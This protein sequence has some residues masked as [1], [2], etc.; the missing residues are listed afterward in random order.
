[1]NCKKLAAIIS[2]GLI[3]SVICA[4]VAYAEA[5]IDRVATPTTTPVTK[6]LKPI[7]D[8]YFEL[9]ENK[10]Y[11]AQ[12]IAV[13]RELKVDPGQTF[14]V[15]VFLKNTGSMPWFSNKSMCLGPK[16][17]LG[18]DSPRDE[19]SVFYSEKLAGWESPNRI[20]MDQLK[21]SPGEIASFTFSGLAPKNSDALKQFFTPVLKN[22]QWIDNV[23][24]NTDVVVGDPNDTAMDLRKKLF[25][26]N[27]SG[28]ASDID[29]NGEKLL[30]VD[31][32]E[33]K[34][35][36]LLDGNVVREFPVSTG[37]SA[38]PTPV[39]QT[40]IIL[41]QEVRVA[42]STPH[43]IMPKY[44]MYRAGGYGFH[45]L[46]SLGNDGGVFWTEARNHMGRPVS[47]GCIRLLPEDANFAFDFTDVGTKVVIEK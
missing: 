30:K 32:S 27:V 29:L 39:G 8:C 6:E 40:K 42:N 34:L 11:D 38:H 18:T 3:I 44:M 1:M 43:Y 13:K 25:Y 46:P 24:F 19:A 2:T 10:T 45:A 17:S 33:Q 37:G 12:L 9:P 16:M 22:L 5:K 41:K 7:E 47:H 21:I 23:K 4:T 28:S 14:Q 15:K 20:G 35:Q 31:L 26:K 36:V